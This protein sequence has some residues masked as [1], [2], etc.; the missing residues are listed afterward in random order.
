MELYSVPEELRTP[1]ICLAAIK[2]N[3]DALRYVPKDLKRII[4][5]KFTQEQTTNE[6]LNRYKQLAGIQ[7]L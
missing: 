5:D 6:D 2:Q 4:I 7:L 1:E 3:P